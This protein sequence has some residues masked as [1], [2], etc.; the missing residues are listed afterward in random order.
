MDRRISRSS[1]FVKVQLS[2]QLSVQ[3]SHSQI[4]RPDSGS[5]LCSAPVINE[6][7]RSTN[8]LFP[9]CTE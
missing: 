1:V 7:E 6:K 2:V 8:F 4:A 9:E 3:I 5:G